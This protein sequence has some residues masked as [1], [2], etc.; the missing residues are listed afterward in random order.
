MDHLSVARNVL[1]LEARA[2]DDVS[3]RLDESFS[4]AV[5]LKIGRAHV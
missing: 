4:K 1:K 5:E 3:E 2:I